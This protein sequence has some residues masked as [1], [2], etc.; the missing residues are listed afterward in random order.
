MKPKIIIDL[1]KLTHNANA[2]AELTKQHG[3]S[4]A[5]VTKVF[6]ANPVMVNALSA[7]PFEYLADSRLENIAAYPAHAPQKRMLL[8]L[9]AHSEAEEVVRLCDVS[10]NSEISTL[11]KLADAGKK[12]GKAHG[13]VL[14]IDLGDLREGIFYSDTEKL[15]STAEYIISR[16]SLDFVGIGTNL[17]CYGSVRPTVENLGQLISIAQNIRT[18]Y[19]INLPMVSGGNS[20]SLYLL[21]NG[22]IPA[23]INNLRFGEGIICGTEAAFGKPFPGLKTNVV[24]LEAEIIEIADKPSMPEGQ[25]NFNAFGETVEYKDKGIH[26]RAILAVGRQDLHQDGLT[27]LE[28]GVEIIGASSDHLIADISG[29]KTPLQVGGKLS[30]AMSYGAILSAFTSKYVDKIY[31]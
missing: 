5:A 16:K 2:L 11:A 21:D 15:Y 14:M 9:P 18:K 31:V 24:T 7:L 22:D 28:D 30:S 29:A 8:R 3:I 12:L 19:G 6:C 4:M 10:L 23:G 27:C 20:S 1:Q 26:R 25:R 17:T 13:V